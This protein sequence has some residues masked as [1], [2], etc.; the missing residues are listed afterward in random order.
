M[1]CVLKI[2]N[3]THWENFSSNVGIIFLNYLIDCSIITFGT[4]I[5]SV[6][7]RNTSTKSK[8]KKVLLD[9]KW[10]CQYEFIIF[11]FL[12]NILGEPKT[13]YST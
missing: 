11:Y 12:K 4:K 7:K 10:K 1:E 5:F 2:N 3:C 8:K 13:P 6:R 9:L